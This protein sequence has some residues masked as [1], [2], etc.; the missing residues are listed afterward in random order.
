VLAAGDVSRAAALFEESLAV[1]EPAGYRGSGSYRAGS[2]DSLLGLGIVA[3][4]RG[5]YPNA[6]RQLEES[7]AS[8]RTAGDSEGAA[9]ALYQLGLVAQHEDGGAR[10]ADLLRESLALRHARGDRLGAAECVEAMV[11]V[12]RGRGSLVRAAQL[13][14]LAGSL[15]EAVGAPRWAIDQAAYD[16]EIAALRAAMGEEAFAAAFTAGR[17]LT[18]TDTEQTFVLS[19]PE[20]R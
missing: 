20:R 16:R 12:A 11:S 3:R 2:A 17:S 6:R 4:Y 10:A 15:R 5:D 19:D 1:R 9:S 14:G 18:P 13:A 7:L 8:F